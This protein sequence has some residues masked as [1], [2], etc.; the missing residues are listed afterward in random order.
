MAMSQLALAKEAVCWDVGAGTGSVSI[1]MALQARRGKVYA[2]EKNETALVLLNENR[3]RF[4]TKNLAIVPGTAPEACWDLPAPTHV[5][6]GGSAGNLRDI[7][8]LAWEKNP[9]VRIVVAAITLESVAE[10]NCIVKDYSF[11]ETE[12]T[13]LNVSRSREAGPYHLMAAQNPVY[14]FTLQ[15][16]EGAV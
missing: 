14:L 3:E 4:H 1:E 7:I 10:M 2:V 15:R 9:E 12:I 13:C 11:I 5:F 16:R 8:E 6:I